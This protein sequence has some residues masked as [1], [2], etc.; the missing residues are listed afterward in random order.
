MNQF[1]RLTVLFLAMVVGLAP[2]VKAAHLG[3]FRFPR[4]CVTKQQCCLP[5]IKHR[6]CHKMVTEEIEET[7]YKPVYR[8]VLCEE[9][10]TVCKPVTEFRIREVRS[11]VCKPVIEERDEIRHFTVLKPTYEQKIQE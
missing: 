11:I 9:T 7:C 4:G 10:V 6:V 8:T 3:V 2:A 1:I 5:E